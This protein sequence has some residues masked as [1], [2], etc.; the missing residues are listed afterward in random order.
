ME[1]STKS[2]SAA[3]QLQFTEIRLTT[4]NSS[5]PKL[6]VPETATTQ[7]FKPDVLILH[8]YA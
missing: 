7:D 2:H 5:M 6:Y 8:A 4:L 1:I 3:Q